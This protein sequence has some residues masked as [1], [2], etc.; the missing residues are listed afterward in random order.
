MDQSVGITED[1]VQADL[2]K[3]APQA[4]KSMLL[5]LE[6][7]NLSAQDFAFTFEVYDYNSKLESAVECVAS[8]SEL[9]KALT[10]AG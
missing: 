6:K 5:V 10:I 2:E 9:N 1:D 8:S 3:M 7:S 4:K